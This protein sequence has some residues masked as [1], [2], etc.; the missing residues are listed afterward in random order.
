[1]SSQ[2]EKVRMDSALPWNP[3]RVMTMGALPSASEGTDTRAGSRPTGVSKSKG[4]PEQMPWEIDSVV[5]SAG[6]GAVDVVDVGSAVEGEM[7]GAVVGTDVVVVMVDG[8]AV[9]EGELFDSS[10]EDRSR[11]GM[12]PRNSSAITTRS[13]RGVGDGGFVRSAG[14]AVH[15]F[16]RGQEGG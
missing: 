5:V 3:C 4:C 8:V 9:L 7:A 6:S 15:P 10:S 11:K 1:M 2:P 14:K 12:R 16:G 13:P